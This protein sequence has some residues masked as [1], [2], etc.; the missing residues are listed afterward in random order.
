M[1]S[2]ARDQVAAAVGG[3][4][5]AA[6]ADLGWSLPEGAVEIERPGDPRHGDYATS[7]ALRLA[8]TLREAP[9]EIARGIR[10]RVA[11]AGPRPRSRWR[12]PAS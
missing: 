2:T 3:A 5:R 1:S 7:V 11:I 6:A 8:K 12:A 4:L 10:A 9:P